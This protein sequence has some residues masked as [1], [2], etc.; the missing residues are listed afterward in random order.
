MQSA[1][2]RSRS[3][4]PRAAGHAASE[5]RRPATSARRPDPTTA[6]ASSGIHRWCP[7]GS[8]CGDRP[9][10]RSTR[11]TAC[12]PGWPPETC[13]SPAPHLRW[14]AR[15]PSGIPVRAAPAAIRTAIKEADVGIAIFAALGVTFPFNVLIGIPLYYQLLIWASA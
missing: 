9:P 14:T 13:A 7:A 15:H 11:R 12:A 5:K 8:A 6:P 1:A 3:S 10:R 4:P 2:P